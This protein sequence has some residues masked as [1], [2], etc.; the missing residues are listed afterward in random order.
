MNQVYYLIDEE[1]HIV[2]VRENNVEVRLPDPSA[3]NGRVIEIKKASSDGF[4]V[5]VTSAG[6]GTIDGEINYEL[7]YKY[8]AITLVSAND[9]WFIF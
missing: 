3:H 5:L 6:G 9:E 4:I 1:T 2:V 8:E 7:N